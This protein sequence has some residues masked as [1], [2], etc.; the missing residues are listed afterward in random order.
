MREFFRKKTFY[1]VLL[2]VLLGLTPLLWFQGNKVILGHDAGLPLLPLPHFLDRL[3]VWTDRFS[4]GSDQT[5]AI[6]GFFIH[7]IEALVS[8]FGANLQLEQRIVF[9]FWFILPG[10]TMYLFARRLEIE[11]K[12]RFFALPVSIFY[13][14]N[15][16]LLQGW[17]I[18]ERTKFSLYAA[19]PL[20]LLFLF[21]WRDN[22]RS[23]LRT[24]IYLSLL[25]FFLN[26]GASPPLFGGIIVA[27][28]AFLFFY[29]L[30]RI[31]WSKIFQLTKLFIPTALISIGLQTYWML[32]YGY[33][34]LH[35]FSSEVEKAGGENGILGWIDYISKDSSLINFF[36]L[37]G[38]P[39]WYQNPS[40][41][42]AA[43][44]LGNPF[45]IFISFL[46]PFFAFVSLAI[47]KEKQRRKYVFFFTFLA[48]VAM[49]FMAGSHR[50][51]GYLYVLFIEFIPGFIAFRTPFY[52]FA[53]ALWFAYAILIGFTIN[54][55][56]TK[57]Y[58]HRKKVAYGIYGTFFALL[59]LYNYPFFTGVFLD[60]IKNERS[61]RVVV[62]QEVYEF[63][64]WNDTLERRDKKMLSLPESSQNFRVDA[65][66]WGYWS[67][68][69]AT[70][71]LTN[72][73][74]ISQTAYNSPDQNALLDALY[75]LMKKNDPEWKNLAHFLGI[76]SFLL[77]KDFAW[78][79]QGTETTNPDYYEKI[80]QD[81][82]LKLVREFGAWKIYDFKQ[83]VSNGDISLSSKIDYIQGSPA[84]AV[85]L[86]D[87]DAFSSAQPMTFD[88]SGEKITKL[89]SVIN[90]VYLMP[91][92]VNCNLQA[93]YGS[94]SVDTPLITHGSKLYPFVEEKLKKE[95]NQFTQNSLD[96]AVYYLKR[97]LEESQIFEKFVVQEKPTD[98]I[99]AAL[100][101]QERTFKIFT[102]TLH[103]ILKEKEKNATNIEL[104]K[105]RTTVRGQ[106]NILENQEEDVDNKIFA[107]LQRN[108]DLL[109]REEE[110]LEKM[111]WETTTE[112]KKRFFIT[113]PQ[114]DFYH[115][116]FIPDGRTTPD[117][118][119][120]EY[121]LDNTADILQGE[122]DL[123][124]TKGQH[125]LEIKDP[126][127]YLRQSKENII[128][129]SVDKNN[130]YNLGIIPTEKNSF[131]RISFDYKTLG[132]YNMQL[133]TKFRRQQKGVN[134]DRETIN[135]IPNQNEYL[136]NISVSAA[137]EDFSFAICVKRGRNMRPVATEISSFRIRKIKQPTVLLY[138][139]KDGI[140]MNS[141]VASQKKSQTSYSFTLPEINKPHVVTLSKTFN[142][143]WLLDQKDPSAIEINGYGNGWLIKSNKGNQKHSITYRVQEFLNSGFIISGTTLAICLVAL[144]ILWRKKK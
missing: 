33:Y 118:I 27:L 30:P 26:G 108:I 94:Y 65:Y 91:S 107:D 104:L 60:Y 71:L 29:F 43:T 46:I 5:Y 2:I 10:I 68:A 61:M 86:L 66:S 11:L 67:L 117:E 114:D 121:I 109:A 13:M 38:V 62:P 93:E 95:E 1:E 73:P 78:E 77:K 17:F 141:N 123:Y 144:F 122:K 120:R 3:S 40:H 119:S 19:L 34:V 9:C 112:D 41:P 31:T 101:E 81:P 106:L 98:L 57:F 133:I 111:I 83:P 85:Y 88:A 96:K 32:P 134:E 64:K 63:G 56:I 58:P 6:A 127:E 70:S 113:I 53:P 128:L 138:T 80:L 116:R 131:Y 124:L 76:Q 82:D 139:S 23:T 87:I 15:H 37:Q 132:K 69:P 142:S 79:L 84:T 49:I 136:R 25:F 4:F 100:L 16:F 130:C 28:L 51:F 125:R 92:C 75:D 45:F 20:M 18:V 143:N 59:L 135:I 89:S 35:N 72:A 8:M 47:I 97:S 74:I 140:A 12:M 126:V 105:I 44:I 102:Q 54:Y 39:E 137:G 115:F 50:P 22:R 55:L 42:Y 24:S 36:R 99:R 129:S 14:L 90:N 21:D 110:S 103:A 48:L 52:K 7:G